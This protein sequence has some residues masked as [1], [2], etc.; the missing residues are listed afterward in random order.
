MKDT[1]EN[2][3]RFKIYMSDE[4]VIKTKIYFPLHKLMDQTN[5]RICMAQR[6]KTI[7]ATL[8]YIVAT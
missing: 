2:D 6:K 4:E 3:I 8:V 7:F 5:W 1:P